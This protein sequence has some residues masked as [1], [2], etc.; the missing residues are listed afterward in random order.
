[1]LF[2]CESEI[3]QAFE[4]YAFLFDHANPQDGKARERFEPIRNV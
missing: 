3:L 1:L 4:L 2:P